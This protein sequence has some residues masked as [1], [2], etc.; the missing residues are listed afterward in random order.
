MLCTV[1]ER[2]DVNDEMKGD[3]KKVIG[4]YGWKKNN[5]EVVDEKYLTTADYSNN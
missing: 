2:R 5:E 1:R 3:L 4:S